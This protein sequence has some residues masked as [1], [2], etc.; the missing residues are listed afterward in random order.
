MRREKS[1][2]LRPRFRRA[3]VALAE[4]VA[5]AAEVIAAKDFEGVF[6]V[7][8]E[9]AAKMAAALAFEVAAT[10]CETDFRG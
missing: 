4:L 2:I 7:A 9:E 8:A 10:A 5:A 3:M 1:R 6:E